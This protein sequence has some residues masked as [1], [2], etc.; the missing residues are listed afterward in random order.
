MIWLST[1]HWTSRKGGGVRIRRGKEGGGGGGYWRWEKGGGMGA[2]WHFCNLK[3][4]RR[5]EGRERGDRLSGA[6]L[7]PI[8]LQDTFI[9]RLRVYW[10]P[11]SK[12]NWTLQNILATWVMNPKTYKACLNEPC[13]ITCFKFIR[14]YTEL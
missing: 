1:G 4:C 9:T 5:T 12:P 3:G 10:T 11:R 6:H 7:N 14:L 13:Q 8:H 2:I